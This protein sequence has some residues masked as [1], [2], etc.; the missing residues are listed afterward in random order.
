[1]QPE[2]KNNPMFLLKKPKLNGKA[3]QMWELLRFLPLYIS[4][5]DTCDPLWMMITELTEVGQLLLAPKLS[6]SQVNLLEALIADYLDSRM[7]L[8]PGVPLR[9][10]HHYLTHYPQFIR[11]FGPP[12]RFWTLR[13]ES[14]HKYFKSVSRITQ[15]YIN[16]THTLSER[17][18]LL[19]SH[20][21][22]TTRF[23]SDIDVQ[24]EVIVIELSHAVQQLVCGFPNSL[25][26]KVLTRCGIHYK[27]GMVIILGRQNSSIL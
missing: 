20:L 1:M 7:D 14:K 4:V 24:H 25:A 26:V 22:Q 17:H 18:Q 21:G 6:Y 11:N 15:N 2:A 13:F 12:I 10:K 19:Q 9:P 27:T 8:F 23:H 3:V 5:K 16:I